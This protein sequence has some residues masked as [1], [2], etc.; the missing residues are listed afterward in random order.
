[1]IVWLLFLLL[2]C[3]K[4]ACEKRVGFR[5]N[6][7]S[8]FTCRSHETHQYSVGEPVGSDSVGE[9]QAAAKQRFDN[10]GQLAQSIIVAHR[11]MPKASFAFTFYE[12]F[13]LNEPQRKS[14]FDQNEEM[15][16]LILHQRHRW[17]N[18]WVSVDDR[19]AT[20]AHTKK[21]TLMWQVGKF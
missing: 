16:R 12:T 10:V 6:S 1:M 17:P 2:P 15:F 19:L 21:Q 18:E 14:I 20:A 7:F 11:I 4:N 9:V 13:P 3:G 8:F 5:V